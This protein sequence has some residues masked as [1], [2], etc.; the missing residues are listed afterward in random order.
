MLINE[1]MDGWMEDAPCSSIS[2]KKNMRREG[3]KE[4]T[5]KQLRKEGRNQLIIFWSG[6]LNAHPCPFPFIVTG[7]LLFARMDGRVDEEE[8]HIYILIT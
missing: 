7:T 1:L 6:R 8:I 2:S 5:R 3:R 4:A